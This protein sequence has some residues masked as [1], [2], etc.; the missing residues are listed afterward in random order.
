M[1]KPFKECK[2]GKNRQYAWDKDKEYQ[3]QDIG[4]DIRQH[5]FNHTLETHVRDV[6]RNK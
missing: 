1:R 4:A 5:L 3:E 6:G 2:L